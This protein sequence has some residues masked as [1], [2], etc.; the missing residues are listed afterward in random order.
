M[1]IGGI[2]ANRSTRDGYGD[3]LL[4][5]G[6]DERIVVLDADLS[7]STKTAAF[8]NKYPERF[9]DCGIAEANMMATA[10]GIATCGKIVFASSFAM[11]AAGRA[12]EQIRNSV[13]YSNLNVKIA[14]THA[15]VTVGEDGGSHQCLEDIAVMRAIPN[16]TVMCP[17]DYNEA[18]QAIRA[19]AEH[20]GPVYIRLG[21]PSVP[22]LG[23]H[24]FKFGKAT[25]V[26]EGA[27]ATVIATGIM[28]SESI[29]AAE[30]LA[31]SGVSI[32]IVDMSTI[33]PI[34]AEIIIDSAVK[35]GAIVTAEEHSII[36]GLGSAVSEVLAEN[37]PT[38]AK[39]IGTRD[40]FGRSGKPAELIEKY[41]LNASS[42]AAAVEE[43][44]AKKHNA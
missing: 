28:V 17:A 42:I 21:R 24:E 30:I 44:L 22:D 33:K 25:I 18:K 39:R 37:C 40:V 29:K 7:G 38:I 36:G 43:I 32:R 9:F 35:T 19:A 34:D 41:G 14:A 15:G 1:T 8:A 11:F 16:M 3:A 6:Q 23:E 13:C 31:R 2:M 12:F 20:D 26:R 27:D 5:L 4:E 10:A